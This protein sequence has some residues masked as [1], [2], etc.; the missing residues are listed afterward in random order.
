MK[1]RDET[2]SL[3]K[4]QARPISVLQYAFSPTARVITYQAV[5]RWSVGPMIPAKMQICLVG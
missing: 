1:D 2:I 3:G 5:A 4:H